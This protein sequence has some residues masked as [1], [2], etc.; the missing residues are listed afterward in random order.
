MNGGL[1][2]DPGITNRIQGFLSER[3][4]VKVQ[5]LHEVA[6]E[7]D[8]VALPAGTLA[9]TLVLPVGL[10]LRSYGEMGV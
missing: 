4:S 9:G 3:L 6:E 10:A 1:A 8:R 5:I 7:N 2:A